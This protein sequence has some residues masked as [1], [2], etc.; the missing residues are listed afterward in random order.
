[1][2]ELT[3]SIL[4]LS[5]GTI[6][7]VLLWKLIGYY[8]SKPSD[9]GKIYSSVPES[10]PVVFVQPFLHLPES[11]IRTDC[12]AKER[13]IQVHC[14]SSSWEILNVSD[15]SWL[16]V[17]KVNSGELLVRMSTNFTDAVRR[18]EIH[19]RLLSSENILESTLVVIQSEL[20]YYPELNLSKD[21]Y[22]QSGENNAT[23]YPHVTPDNK[24]DE[25]KI[26]ALCTSDEGTWCEVVPAVGVRMRGSYDLC[27]RTLP[28]PANVS[29][30]TAVVTLECG[31][32]PF[33]TERSIVINQGIVFTYYIEYPAFDPCSRSREAIETPLSYTRED[34]VK[35]YTIHVRCNINWKI[36]YTP[37]DWVEIGK[38]EPEGDPYNAWFT[39][40]VH[41]NDQG[42]PWNGL[43]AARHMIISLVTEMGQVHDVFVYQGGYVV[44]NGRR[45]LDRNLKGKNILTCNAIPLGLSAK[46]Q[47]I[48]GALFRFGHTDTNWKDVPALPASE[49]NR[50]TNEHP[51]RN[52]DSDPCP[53]GWRVPSALELSGLFCYQNYAFRYV[54]DRWHTLFSDDGVP[55]FFPLAGYCS[56]INGCLMERKFEGRYWS[57]TEYSPIYADALILR[58]AKFPR[59]RQE[60]KKQS[61]SVR[62]V[63]I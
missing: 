46:E 37:A 36:M 4:L 34:P 13:S 10:A 57:C 61:F 35:I 63:E 52:D 51:V 15:S 60:L 29:V 38:T 1:M 43:Y 41:P 53:K 56:H 5:A 16:N 27:I 39:V 21:L 8:R 11:H 19:I 55:V 20:G 59:Q 2:D 42:T 40:I 48:D 47:G 17:E 25:W 22:I 50:N 62:P 7:L 28:K 30:R 9:A 32:Y 12:M 44:I 14:S 54:S 18:T 45:W 6:F 49:W 58:P 24:C 3:L 26:K 31:T 23:A 33:N